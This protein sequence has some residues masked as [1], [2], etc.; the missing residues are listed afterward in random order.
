MISNRFL[1]VAP[2]I[3]RPLSVSVGKREEVD[4]CVVGGGIIGLATAREINIR[5]PNLKLSVVEKE[6][7]LAIHQSGSN[8]GRL[9]LFLFSGPR[10][11]PVKRPLRGLT[12]TSKGRAAAL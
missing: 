10:S 4:V 7:E 1:R 11:G 8:S 2:A 9:Y 3:I 5:H 6:N 12:D